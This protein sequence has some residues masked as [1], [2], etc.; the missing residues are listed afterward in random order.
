M[1]EITKSQRKMSRMFDQVK[2][3]ERRYLNALHRK[4]AEIMHRLQERMETFYKKQSN[5]KGELKKELQDIL[6]KQEAFVKNLP[7][8]K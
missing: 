3:T 7:K 2:D 4:D 8:S 1:Q 5:F 6:K